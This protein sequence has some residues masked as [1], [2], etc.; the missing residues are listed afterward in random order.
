MISTNRFIFSLCKFRIFLARIA[1][2]LFIVVA[3]FPSD[4]PFVVDM[5]LQLV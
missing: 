2:G 4:H 3:G 1:L 5:L